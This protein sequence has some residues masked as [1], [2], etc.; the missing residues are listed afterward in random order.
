[1][2]TKSEKVDDKKS[3]RR[4]TSKAIGISL[5][6]SR[7]RKHV[8]KFCVNADVEAACAELKVLGDKG[9]VNTLSQSTKD[10][11]AKAYATVY[12][13]RKTKHDA[14]VAR[15]KTS[16]LP[17]DAKKL[18][19]LGAFPVRTNSVEEQQDYAGKLRWRFSQDSSVVLASALDY[20]IQDIVRTAMVNAHGMGK[21]IIQVNHVVQGDFSSS[22]MYPLINQLKVVQDALHATD[23]DEKEKEKEKDEVDTEEPEEDDDDGDKNKTAHF[24]FYINLICKS[25][26]A[27]LVA[28]DESYSSIRI[29]QGIREFGSDVVTQ[30]IQ[31][32]SPLIKLYAST[33][34]I[35]TVSDDVI[36]FI[37]KFL[38]TDSGGCPAG[39]CGFMQERVAL[40]Q[41]FNTK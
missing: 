6:T 10:I 40:Y 25:V 27:R 12:D 28:E 37:F 24:R 36:S 41:K 19:G 2:P 18:K 1:M 9:D 38:L 11:V 23:V 21:A 4:Q 30:L 29:S 5:S 17:A 13:P 35:K 16:K 8:D 14:L 32:I 15:L 20:V 3:S 26:K 7:V 31:R 34:K 33:A 22:S 39:F